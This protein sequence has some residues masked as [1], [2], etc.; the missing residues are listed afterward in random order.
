MKQVLQYPKRGM[1]VIEE[2]P[3]PALKSGGVIIANAVSLVSAGTERAMISL[4]E[5]SLIGKA[6]ARPDL[7][8]QVI[9][10]ARAEG[11][12]NT[13][14]KVRSR[15]EA[16]TPLGYSCA[17]VIREVARECENEFRVGQRVAAAGFGY[18]SHADI[19]FAPK[20][21]C[22]SIPDSVTMEEASF[23]TLGAIA[24][25]GVRQANP[26]L[27]ERVAIIGMG[28]LGQL[29]A[30]IV[31]AN[32]CLAIGLDINE[33]KLA[34]ARRLGCDV[35][36]NNGAHSV[37][38][39]VLAAT[40]GRGA[41]RVIVTAASDSAEIMGLAARVARDRGLVTV[42]GAVNMTLDRRPFYDKELTMN[43]SRSYG[44]GR[45]D[46]TYEERGVDYP[47]SYVRWT[48]QRNMVCFLELIA[49]GRVNVRDLIT[50][51]F[52]IEEAMRAYDVIMGRVGAEF[53]GV[54]LSYDHVSDHE[55]AQLAD[56][57]VSVT[58]PRAHPASTVIGAIGAG[59]FGAGVLYPHLRAMKDVRLERIV[60]TSG[61]KALSVA[62]QFGF[63]KAG[64]SVAETLADETI[65]AVI[66]AT[67]HNLHA[68]QVIAALDAGKNVFVEK[69]LATT[70][71]ELRDIVQAR[72]RAPGDLMV[73]FNRRFAPAIKVT[74][75]RLMQTAGP[76]MITYRVNA[77]FIPASHSLQDPEIGKGRIIGEMCH[78]IDTAIYLTGAEVT[79]VQALAMHDPTGRYLS[80]DNITVGLTFADGSTASIAYLAC[81]AEGLPKERIEVHHQGSSYI[82]EDFVRAEMWRNG[83]KITLWSGAQDKG[84]R[85]ELA[86]F[87]GLVTGVF[88]NAGGMRDA[89]A[90][91]R[92]TLAVCEALQTGELRRPN[93]E[94]D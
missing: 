58:K 1:T 86:A 84:H 82:V 53:L 78:F 35:T 56:T 15:L 83:K 32:G 74:R 50:H 7:V 28:L 5:Q 51:R 30:Q 14:R 27:G 64:T 42:V 25:Q 75:E 36:I 67:P 54:T 17:G 85:N 90:A 21:L 88:D 34:L 77:G 69:P 47:L 37:L 89:I 73:G 60:A 94:I 12:L 2:V 71:D 63:S 62:K 6:K 33:T 4:A 52:T 16:P 8:R 23:V 65:N 19:I 48:E 46:T 79:G 59:N 22:A 11:A 66:I 10:K 80:G 44:P 9:A 76:K 91:T 57:S 13:W 18:A 3:T 72:K 87:V 45:Y 31:R 26:T 20:H 70:I 41:D 68:Q 49:T 43:L 92:A 40:G 29:T 81:G 24:L 39:A 93:E 61:V 55:K 38:D